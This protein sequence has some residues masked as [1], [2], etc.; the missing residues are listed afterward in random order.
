M[1]VPYPI[2]YRI[3]RVKTEFLLVFHKMTHDIDLIYVSSLLYTYI[4]QT[5]QGNSLELG[6]LSKG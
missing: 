6:E 3:G 2:K 1:P 5:P 4:H